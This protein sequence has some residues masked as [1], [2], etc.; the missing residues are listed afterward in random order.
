MTE[1]IKILVILPVIDYNYINIVL[2]KRIPMF[3]NNKKNGNKHFT[4][5]S[6]FCDYIYL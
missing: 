4:L 1:L 6:R 2:I 3:F 5:L